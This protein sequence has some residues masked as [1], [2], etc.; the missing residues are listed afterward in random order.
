MRFTKND[1][2][3]RRLA[4]M[5]GNKNAIRCN[6]IDE[7]LAWRL[8]I[9][10]WHGT[11]PAKVQHDL[12][13]IQFPDYVTL[14]I[15]KRLNALYE[16]QNANIIV[17]LQLQRNILLTLGRK[18]T[19]MIRMSNGE[20][21]SSCRKCKERG[22]EYRNWDSM[23]Y[24]VD[25]RAGVYC[26]NCAVEIARSE[27]PVDW[28]EFMMRWLFDYAKRGE[29]YYNHVDAVIDDLAKYDIKTNPDDLANNRKVFNLL[30][31]VSGDQ[32]AKAFYFIALIAEAYTRIYKERL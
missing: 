12:E 3:T 30:Y 20:G 22:I 26:W 9:A 10:R 23:M 25:G 28:N 16:K 15:V 5:G 27:K 13:F 29:L 4:R 18:D 2:R 14:P 24:T 32:T 21:Q 8:R 6:H 11:M 17:A 19:K 1:P 31:N 7:D